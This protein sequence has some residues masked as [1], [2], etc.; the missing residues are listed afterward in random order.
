[1]EQVRRAALAVAAL[2]DDARP[3]NFYSFPTPKGEIVASDMYPPLDHP[4][5][6]DFFFFV[7]L[8]NYGFWHGDGRGYVRPLVGRLGGKERKGSDMLWRVCMRQ[9]DGDPDWFLPDRLA[10]MPESELGD[11]VFVDDEGP[12]A[13]PDMERRALVTRQYGWALSRWMEPCDIL[14]VSND[15]E[16]SLSAFLTIMGV[17]PGYNEDPLEKRQL[18]LAMALHNRPERLLKVNDPERWFPVMDYHL[19]RLCLRT[20]MV[21]LEDHELERNRQRAWVDQDTW[22][23][24]R[25]PCYDAL[26][27]VIDLSGRGHAL[28]DLACWKARKYCPEMSEPDCGECHFSGFCA[29]RTDL[30]QSVIRTTFC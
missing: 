17:I 24:I 3:L 16:R 27:A 4:R 29:R 19:E 6:A 13:F 26:T 18:L 25:Q 5:A 2:P 11:R 28:T 15:D 10:A 30:F 23:G 20:G 7:M 9:F 12:I 22:Y 21:E 8:H 1:M 14:M